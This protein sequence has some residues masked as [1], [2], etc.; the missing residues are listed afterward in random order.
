MRLF[1]ATVMVFSAFNAMF[2]G[3]GYKSGKESGE[4]PYIAFMRNYT[5]RPRLRKVSFV[6][7]KQG[8]TVP[9]NFPRGQIDVLTKLI[10]GT[11]IAI[12][13]GRIRMYYD[14]GEWVLNKYADEVTRQ[15]NELDR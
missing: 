4:A 6:L 9:F 15:T 3:I 8:I 11:D 5:W 14:G 2:Y 7:D 13:D 1:I 10:P 12:E